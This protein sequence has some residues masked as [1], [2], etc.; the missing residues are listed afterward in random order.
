MTARGAFHSWRECRSSSR[1]QARRRKWHHAEGSRRKGG[2]GLRV[3]Q[4]NVL[5][6]AYARAAWLPY[7]KRSSLNWEYRKHNLLGEILGYNADLICLQEVDHFGDFFLPELRKRG[8]DGVFVK[9]PSPFKK[10]GCCIFY[11]RDKFRLREKFEIQFN[12]LV[13]RGGPRFHTNNVAV[14]LSLV[15]RGEGAGGG[16]G[17]SLMVGCVHLFHDPK[18]ADIKVLQ[19]QMMTQAI[20]RAATG[21][22]TQ[23]ALILCGDFNSQPGDL[24]YHLLQDG[25]APERLEEELGGSGWGKTLVGGKLPLSNAYM[26][27]MGANLEVTNFT[28]SFQG[29]LDYIWMTPGAFDVV[30]VLEGIDRNLLEEEARPPPLDYHPRFT[31]QRG[32]TCIHPSIPLLLQIALPN[33]LFSSDHVALVCDLMPVADPNGELPDAT[34]VLALPGVCETEA[35]VCQGTARMATCAP[36]RTAHNGILLT[37]AITLIV[38]G[39]I[40]SSPTVPCVTCKLLAIAANAVSSTPMRVQRVASAAILAAA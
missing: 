33:S 36:A 1:A 8:Y 38:L 21:G 4:Y 10:D 25:V 5:A 22:G 6:D 40:A 15:L 16:Q 28:D 24:V 31:P 19:S 9:R 17:S 18:Q 26:A 20:L 3:L 12:D 39:G 30:R 7:C 35:H 37:A 29:C 23:D 13:R 14:L 34:L 11:R 32:L 27:G 2:K